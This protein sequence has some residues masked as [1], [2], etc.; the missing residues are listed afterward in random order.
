MLFLYT[1]RTGP[2][3]ECNA[4]YDRKTRY[5]DGRPGNN[6]Q[7][8]GPSRAISDRATQTKANLETRSSPTSTVAQGSYSLSTVPS[9]GKR[10]L[11]DQ[12]LPYQAV[13]LIA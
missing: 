7:R 6:A 13:R 11:R 3:V 8:P 9:C 4:G 5:T 10:P 12:Q 2:V 1:A